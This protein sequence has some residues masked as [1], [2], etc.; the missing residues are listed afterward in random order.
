MTYGFK[1]SPTLPE[2]WHV[3]SGKARRRFGAASLMPGG[4]GWK[5]YVPTGENQNNGYVE[6]MACTIFG[7]LN[8]YETLANLKGYTDFP[9]DCAERFN[10]I[11]AGIT[12]DGGDIQNSCERI[13]QF[14][15]ISQDKLPF[16]DSIKT[17]EQFYA[18]IPIPLDLILLAKKIVDTFLLGDEWVFNGPATD[19]AGKLVSALERGPVAVSMYAWKRGKGNI[20]SKSPSDSDNHWLQLI[21][22]KEGEYWLVRDQYAPYDKKIAW[23]TDFYCAKLYFLSLR[24]EQQGLLLFLQRQVVYLMTQLVN[25]LKTPQAPIPT[26]IPNPT[27]MPT[28]APEPVP[29]PEILLWDTPQN[30]Y[31]ATRVVCDEVGLTFDQKEI[32]CACVYQE[33]QFRNYKAPGIPTTNGNKDKNGKVWSTDYGIAQVND[34]WNIGPGKPFPSVS[35]VLTYPEE[36]IRWMAGIYKKTGALQPWASY[37]SGAYKPWLKPNSPMRALKTN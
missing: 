8:C 9:K 4:H 23:D 33:S 29:A 30:A 24:S 26:V 35:Y 32:L 2:H 3:G 15:V 25:A 17:W 36:V 34:Y 11:L 21:D 16:D 22:F 10:A 1:P 20:Y 27:P 12:K 28:P 31:H 6:T 37:T 14:G 7:T 13:R 19:K 5:D 18:P